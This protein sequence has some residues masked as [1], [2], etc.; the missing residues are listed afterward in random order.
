MLKS[1]CER[2]GS[3][4]RAGARYCYWCG[5]RH[6][7]AR[8]NPALDR[9]APGS[10]RAAAVGAVVL[11]AL[12]AGLIA[13]VVLAFRNGN[14][15]GDAAPALAA[16]PATAEGLRLATIDFHAALLEAEQGHNVE[17]V[18]GGL[19]RACRSAWSLDDFRTRL[20]TGREELA[21]VYGVQPAD[22]SVTG[23]EVRNVNE[24][25]GESYALVRSERYPD[26]AQRI[27]ADATFIRAVYED[28]N[29]RFHLC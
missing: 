21:R 25:G 6:R 17:R 14:D 13:V 5:V 9:V 1:L 12:A 16:Q 2:C 27:N 3:P 11:G 29:W 15:N 7:W 19:S 18:Y 24:T 26:V 8:F 22:L 23:A 10:R 4:V 28:G 20:E